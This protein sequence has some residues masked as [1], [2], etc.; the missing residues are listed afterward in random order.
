[1]DNQRKVTRLTKRQQ[2]AL[3]RFCQD[4][5]FDYMEKRRALFHVAGVNNAACLEFP[6]IVVVI[7][8]DG[9]IHT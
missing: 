9:H 5:G 1:M 4:R 6:P 3:Q 7:E 8:P 2:Y